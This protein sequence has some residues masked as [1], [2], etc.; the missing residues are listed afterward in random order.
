M[1]LA[2]GELRFVEDTDRF[3]R[4]VVRVELSLDT[5]TTKLLKKGKATLKVKKVTMVDTDDVKVD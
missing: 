2:D 5:P 4:K 1:K 3:N